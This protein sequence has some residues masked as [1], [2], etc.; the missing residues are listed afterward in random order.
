MNESFFSYL[1]RLELITFFS[2]YPLVY[3]LVVSIAGQP[4]SANSSKKR[5]ISL[6]PYAYGLVGLLYLGFQLKKLYPDYSPGHITQLMHYW[7]LTIWGILAIFFLVPSVARKKVVSL[8]HS[9]V[10]FLLLIQDIFSQFINPEIDKSIIRNDM[11]LYTFSVLIN[12]GSFILI[13]LI[14]FLM[15]RLIPHKKS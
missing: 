6:L 14:Y 3:A 5:T 1:H 13:V 7:F 15:R 12:A 2:G 8:L 11:K 4:S 10:F 9:F